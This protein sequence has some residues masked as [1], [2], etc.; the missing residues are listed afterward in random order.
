M[1]GVL[2]MSREELDI[3]I[4]D[5]AAG[6]FAKYGFKHTS[7]QAIADSIGYSKAGLLHHFPS[8]DILWQSVADTCIDMM[9]DLGKIAAS[10]AEGAE[11][12]QALVEYIAEECETHPGFTALI[13]GNI[14]PLGNEQSQ[15]VVTQLTEKAFHA[16]GV[17]INNPVDPERQVR[18]AAAL[19]AITL[20]TLGAMDH[21]TLDTVGPHIVPVALDALGHQSISQPGGSS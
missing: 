7:V 15:D 21:G 12:D 10:A 5:A 11:R 3:Q 4:L 6:L 1:V 13:L 8:K 9:A 20:V 18:V 14:G 2:R 17:D 19:G 16:F